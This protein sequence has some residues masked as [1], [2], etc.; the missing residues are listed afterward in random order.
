LTL[1]KAGEPLVDWPRDFRDHLEVVTR[2]QKRTRIK[3]TEAEESDAIDQANRDRPRVPLE[4][5]H[6]SFIRELESSGYY[7]C[8]CADHNCLVAHTFPIK[9]IKLPG[10]YATK[11]E[12]TDPHAPNCWMYPLKGGGWRVYRFTQ[13]TEEAPTWTTSRN[14]WTTCV[15]GLTPTPAQ[16]AA[17]YHGQRTKRAW[18]YT[19][20]N[21]IK[22]VAAYGAELKVPAWLTKRPRPVTIEVVPSGLMLSVERRKAD[23]KQPAHEAGWL[24]A[25]GPIWFTH[26]ECNTQS[27]Q[28]DYEALADN[29]IRHVARDDEQI[30]LYVMTVHGLQRQSVDQVKNRLTHE[31]FDGA[32]QR[33][34]LG[35]CAKYSWLRVALPFQPEHPGDRLWNKDG[36]Q[37]VAFPSEQ[38][39]PTPYWD[40]AFKHWGQGLNDA[41]ESD[42]WCHTHGIKDGADYLRWWLATVLRFPERRLPMLATYSKENNTGKSFLHEAFALTMTPNGYML[43]DKAIKNQAGFDAELHGKVLCAID[44]VDLS[45]NLDF[46]NA[47]KRWITNPWMNFSFKFQEVFLD[48]NYT[49]WVFTCNDRGHIQVDA[50][51]E[52]IIIWEM[53]PFPPSA[54]IKKPVFT[55][56]LKKEIPYL[57]QKLFALEMFDVHSRLAL[58]PLLTTEKV[59]AVAKCTPSALEGLALKLAEAIKKMKKPYGP[60]TATDLNAVLGNWHNT[61]KKPRSC[62]NS[63]GRYMPRVKSHLAPEIT[64]EIGSDGKLSTYRITETAPG[65]R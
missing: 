41:V 50:W 25:R 6:R 34:L 3:G 62:A 52:R 23:A 44:D 49:H 7:C 43:S 18:L 56:Y 8:W 53:T 65:Q 4:A 21:A 36:V 31:G 24:E 10:V 28:T 15:I 30:G 45:G 9:K 33:D 5:A 38:P 61:M 17:L 29:L 60:G 39:G 54:F 47:L 59:E 20:D 32:L 1:I 48:K 2:K 12:G 42:E 37:L 11:S 46:Y 51:D 16:V 27:Q 57:L 22:A 55:E 19:L 13:G 64:I 14:G 26:I 35:W 58:P 63:L 40:R